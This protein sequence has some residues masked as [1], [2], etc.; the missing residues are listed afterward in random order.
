MAVHVFRFSEHFKDFLAMLVQKPK[1]NVR[2]TLE[3]AVVASLLLSTIGHG[4]HQQTEFVQ[5]S[6]R[7]PVCSFYD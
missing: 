7:C 6:W 1:F 4:L 2:L 3:T 5:L